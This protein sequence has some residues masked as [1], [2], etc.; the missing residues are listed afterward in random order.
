MHVSVCL[1]LYLCMCVSLCVM[2][3]FMWCVCVCLCVVCVKACGEYRLCLFSTQK[4]IYI[5]LTIL[6]SCVPLE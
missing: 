4:H 6:L 3:M 2:H 5:P 1:F